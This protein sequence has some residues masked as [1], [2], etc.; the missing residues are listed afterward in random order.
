MSNNLK[1]EFD[2]DEVIEGIKQGVIRELSEVSFDEAKNSVI[3]QLKSE[4]KNEVKLTYKDES[5]LK[6]EIK[7]EIKDKVYN[8]LIDEVSGKYLI[9]FDSY[10]ETQ[11]TK[12]PDKLDKL[13][14][15]IRNKV[16]NDLYNDLYSS[17]QDEMNTKIKSITTQLINNIG[18]NNLKVAGTEQ[19]ITKEEYDNLVHRNEILEALEQGGVDNWNWYGESLKQYFGEDDEEE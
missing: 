1:F 6:D 3:N 15:D 9:Q 7:K 19:M 18:G 12:N 11:L 17:L 10:V 13:Q 2:F 16:S 4:I 14:S 5:E 8:T